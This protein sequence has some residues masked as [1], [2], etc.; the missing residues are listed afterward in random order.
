MKTVRYCYVTFSLNSRF[1]SI[2]FSCEATSELSVQVLFLCVFFFSNRGKGATNT[3]MCKRTLKLLSNTCITLSAS[4]NS[5]PLISSHFGKILWAIDWDSKRGKKYKIQSCRMDWSCDETQ[6][7]CSRVKKKKKKKQVAFKAS[8][9]KQNK[10]MT[11]C[12]Q[13]L[14]PTWNE[15]WRRQHTLHK[16]VWP[17]HFL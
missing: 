6:M 1:F 11:S 12:L 17:R 9:G 2:S 10:K 14:I 7:C 13:R 5:F 8:K 16:P 3:A 15:N 4:L